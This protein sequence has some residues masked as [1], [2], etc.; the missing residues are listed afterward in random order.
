MAKDVFKLTVTVLVNGEDFELDSAETW[1]HHYHN[2][3]DKEAVKE[4]VSAVLSSVGM[5][6]NIARV[7]VDVAMSDDEDRRLK[8]W[9]AEEHNKWERTQDSIRDVG[10]TL[11]IE[12]VWFSMDNHAIDKLLQ[13]GI[14]F[15]GE[16]RFDYDGG[17]GNAVA[18]EVLTNPTYQD[19]WKA[20]DRA[21]TMSGDSH[22]VFL[23]SINDIGVQNGVRVVTMFFGS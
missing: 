10:N 7:D 2:N 21:V 6:H 12:S 17:W 5:V 18:G 11:G 4:H 22:H 1:E 19:L 14:V 23:E 13:N 3:P 16:V 20:A 15:S 9:H 8:A